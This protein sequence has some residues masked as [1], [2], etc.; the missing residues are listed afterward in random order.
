MRDHQTAGP[1]R[2]DILA[3]SGTLVLGVVGIGLVAIWLVGR[4]APPT[5]PDDALGDILQAAVAVGGL[6]CVLAVGVGAAALVERPLSAR[7]H[8]VWRDPSRH[9][10]HARSTVSATAAVPPHRARHL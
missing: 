10:A 5:E 9:G 4:A 6:L 3:W 2:E 8:T 1:G 7:S